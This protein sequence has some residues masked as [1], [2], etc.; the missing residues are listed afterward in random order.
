MV[1]RG[2]Q[3]CAGAE[4]CVCV[5]VCRWVGGARLRELDVR[6]VIHLCLCLKYYHMRT[7]IHVT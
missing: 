5:C 7:R 6:F 1:Y 4:L 3:V 2:V